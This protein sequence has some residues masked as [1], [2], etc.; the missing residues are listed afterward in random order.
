MTRGVVANCGFAL[1]D[2][3]SALAG[4]ALPLLLLLPLESAHNES[5]FL[6]I[7]GFSRSPLRHNPTLTQT[8][9]TTTRR[10][11]FLIFQFFGHQQENP[12]TR[13]RNSEETSRSSL[14]QTESS[15]T[16]R[17]VVHGTDA[18]PVQQI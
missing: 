18:I 2:T 11:Q 7:S 14:N 3:M 10:W 9:Q 6:F 13:K 17:T 8:P 12:N 16:I 5:S 4:A 1:I 15:S